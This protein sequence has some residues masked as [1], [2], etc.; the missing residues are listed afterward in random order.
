MLQRVKLQRVVTFASGW[1]KFLATAPSL[2]GRANVRSAKASSRFTH[3]SQIVSRSTTT[4]VSSELSTVCSSMLSSAVSS[5]MDI[6]N[7]PVIA[8][9]AQQE[10]QSGSSVTSSPGKF[11]LVLSEVNPVL[12]LTVIKVISFVEHLEHSELE[13]L[14]V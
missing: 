10:L 11:F 1:I 7:I 4:V 5:L 8:G 14:S 6:A 3:E 2:D 9:S 13:L 12:N